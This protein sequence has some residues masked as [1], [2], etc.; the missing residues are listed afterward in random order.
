MSKI[1]ILSGGGARGAFQAGVYKQFMKEGWV[2]D[3]VGGISVGALNGAMIATNKSEKMMLLWKHITPDQ[4]LKKNN[5]WRSARRFLIHKVGIGF[6]NGDQTQPLGY[7]SNKPLE[8]LL[9]KN[10]GN[11]FTMDYFSG[12]VNV[13]TGAYRPFHARRLMV[14]WTYIDKIIASTSIPLVF[15]PVMINGSPHVDGGVRHMTPLKHILRD[16]DPTEI[17]IIT[18]NKYKGYRP[19][20][21]ADVVDIIDLSKRTLD[22]LLN[23]I[24][25]KDLKEFE[26]I[27]RLVNQAH[28]AGFELRK[29][30][31]KPYK[32]YKALLYEPNESLG[33]S[34]NFRSDQARRNMA[35]GETIQPI[36][37]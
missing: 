1:L 12:T 7:Y 24:F 21:N 32:K 31:G 23:E 35:H 28:D 19:E 9:R 26:R 8:K 29:S 37:L 2:P 22:I 30:N 17:R 34:L 25:M 16:Q 5:I 18:C 13:N 10:I 14:P 6:L 36:E 4:V 33:D 11:Q 20:A 27:N 15:N 3:A